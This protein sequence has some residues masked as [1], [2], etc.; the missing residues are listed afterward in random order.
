[1]TAQ[2]GA[3]AVFLRDG[4]LPHCGADIAA[5]GELASAMARLGY[6]GEVPA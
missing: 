1:L 5:T 6:D 2:V 4:K 3:F